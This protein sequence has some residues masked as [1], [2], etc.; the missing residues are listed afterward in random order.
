MKY[1]FGEK[2]TSEHFLS[3]LSLNLS[4]FFFK[5]LSYK[6]KHKKCVGLFRLADSAITSM[7]RL[8]STTSPLSLSL[9]ITA[10]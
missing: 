1:E 3:T 7:Q 10:K 2:P 6:G 9:L 5:L 8:A 4:T